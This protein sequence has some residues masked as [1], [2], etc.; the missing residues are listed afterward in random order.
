MRLADK[1]AIVTGGAGG[2]GAATARRLAAE[3]ARVVVADIAADRAHAVASD[4]G[5]QAIGFAFDA[6]NPDSIESLVAFAVRHF[7]R[8]DILHNNAALLGPLLEQD[9]T[10]V[11]IPVELWDR[12]MAI[13]LRAI[14]LGCR[15]AV[16]RMAESGGGAIVNT[17]SINAFAGDAVRLAYGASKGAIGALSQYVATQHARQ[18]IRCNAIAPGVILTPAIADPSEEAMRPFTRQILSHRLGRPEDIA[19]AVAYLASADAEYVTGT[20]LCVDGGMSAHLPY[21]AD[22][23]AV[24]TAG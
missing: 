9:T 8:L 19:A 24:A 22:L 21:V 13:N 14:F 10:A 17:A 2:I 4:I 15:F 20:V 6:E 1:V 7:G 12:T 16:P 11:D 18:R 3:G 5:P 23:P